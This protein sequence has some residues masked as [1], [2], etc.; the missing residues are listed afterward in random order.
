MILRRMEHDE[1]G[2]DEEHV[3]AP[4]PGMDEA[5]AEIGLEPHRHVPPDDGQ[6][7]KRVVVKVM[8]A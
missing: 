7:R 1:A 6:R 3:H 8:G 2:D 5:V 4:A